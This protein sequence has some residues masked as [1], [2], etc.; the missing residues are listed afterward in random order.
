MCNSFRFPIKNQ[1]IISFLN[2][3]LYLFLKTKK[4]FGYS[5]EIGSIRVHF[6]GTVACPKKLA[7]ILAL[8]VLDWFAEFATTKR[9]LHHLILLGITKAEY[10]LM[11][12]N[13]ECFEFRCDQCRPRPTVVATRRSQRQ[14]KTTTTSQVV[15]NNDLH[16][17][18]FTH[19]F[20]FGLKRIAEPALDCDSSNKPAA[21]HTQTVDE[22]SRLA[23]TTT[24][25]TLEVVYITIRILNLVDTIFT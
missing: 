19:R 13:Y 18:Y 23:E 14:T 17:I 4:L 24:T 1:F 16:I 20:L 11:K 21:Q 7:R 5:F 2:W 10:L 12:R 6:N 9:I 8:F 25:T 3:N 22:A 15:W